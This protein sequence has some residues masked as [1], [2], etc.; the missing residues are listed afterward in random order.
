M[1]EVGRPWR[2]NAGQIS[3]VSWQANAVTMST[4]NGVPAMA[5]SIAGWNWLLN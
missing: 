2:R 1:R 5:F 3:P 4:L